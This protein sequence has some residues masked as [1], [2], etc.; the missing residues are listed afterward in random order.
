MNI[1]KDIT[2]WLICIIWILVSI[3][4]FLC[5]MSLLEI[6]TTCIA[7]F[8]V[9][10]P[11][12]CFVKNAKD[13]RDFKIIENTYALLSKWDDPHF[14]EARKFTRKIAKNNKDM[15]DKDKLD[16]INKNESLEHSII[17][18]LN[19]IQNIKMSLDE[20]RIKK[21]I[22]K[23]HLGE[24]IVSIINRFD[25]YIKENLSDTNKKDLNEL[26]KEIEQ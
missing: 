10:I 3:F 8:G 9:L 19:Y 14:A 4:L 5:K 11:L 12:Y 7:G 18:V 13:D 1:F 17:L 2:F 23:K 6:I 25:C 21:D 24:V 15:S 26:R 22:I 20:Q 16:A